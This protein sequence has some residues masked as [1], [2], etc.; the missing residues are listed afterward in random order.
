MASSG[1]RDTVDDADTS[2]RLSEDKVLRRFR[3]LVLCA[4]LAARVHDEVV[5]KTHDTTEFED[6]ETE[7]LRPGGR[8]LVG[9][10]SADEVTYVAPSMSLREVAEYLRSTDVSLAVVGDQG[11]VHG[12]V[13]ERDIVTAVALGLDVDTTEVRTIET[14]NLKWATATSTIDDVAEEMLENYV[15]HVL[16][17][18]DDGTLIGVVSMRDLLT[19]YLV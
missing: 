7:D 6:V 2:G 13:S 17:A 4:W 3:D 12:V 8:Q 11:Q 10:F 14:E 5:T 16:I 15:R 1:A 19:A 9:G 18:G